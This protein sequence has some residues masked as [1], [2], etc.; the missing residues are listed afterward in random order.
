[1]RFSL[2]EYTKIDVLGPG[3]HWGSLTNWF[4]EAGG[5]WRGGEWRTGGR[6]EKG[7]EGKGG[8]GKG[9]EKWEVGE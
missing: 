2:S 3:P 7:R 4:Q 8:M 6:G 5:E 1:M 9:G